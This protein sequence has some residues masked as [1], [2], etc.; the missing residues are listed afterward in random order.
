MKL[1]KKLNDIF[2]LYLI[3]FPSVCLLILIIVFFSAGTEAAFL[4]QVELLTSSL[5]SQGM[6]L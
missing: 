1:K 6:K 5:D 4:I 2:T 3:I